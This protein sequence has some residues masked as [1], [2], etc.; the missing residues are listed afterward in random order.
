MQVSGD[1]LT[2]AVAKCTMTVFVQF[3]T[4]QPD[5][6]LITSLPGQEMITATMG[7]HPSVQTCKVIPH[8]SGTLRGI[9]IEKRS[10]LCLTY[11]TT[12]TCR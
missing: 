8:K 3:L 5:D 7:S 4:D 11:R 2:D 9:S 10:S 1:A 6:P 12:T